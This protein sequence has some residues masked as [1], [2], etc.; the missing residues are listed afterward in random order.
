MKRNDSKLRAFEP[1]ALEPCD[2]CFKN[3]NK[4]GFD[5]YISCCNRIKRP[6]LDLLCFSRLQMVV[7]NYVVL[8]LKQ[9]SGSKDEK[10]IPQSVAGKFEGKVTFF[11]FRKFS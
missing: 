4:I 6:N 7:L 10:G 9:E 11:E 3:Q 5:R 1:G 2:S 8:F